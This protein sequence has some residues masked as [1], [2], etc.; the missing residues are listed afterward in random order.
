MSKVSETHYKIP[1]QT[2][3]GL[4]GVLQFQVRG[5]GGIG[6]IEPALKAKELV[7]ENCGP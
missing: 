1:V 3:T 6:V 5:L 2:P 7:A 4:A